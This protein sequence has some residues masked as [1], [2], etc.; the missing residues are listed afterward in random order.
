[1]VSKRDNVQGG[2]QSGIDPPSMLL[3]LR[4]CSLPTPFLQGLGGMSFCPGTRVAAGWRRNTEL[5]QRDCRRSAPRRLD[6][7]PAHRGVWPARQRRSRGEWVGCSPG[8]RPTRPVPGKRGMHSAPWLFRS[9]R[10]DVHR[11]GASRLR[12][13]PAVPR[14]Y[15]EPRHLAQRCGC[16]RG[17]DRC[18]KERRHP[19][20]RRAQ[21]SDWESILLDNRLR[22][23]G[24]RYQHGCL[25]DGIGLHVRDHRCWRTTVHRVDMQSNQGVATATTQRSR[26]TRLRVSGEV[27]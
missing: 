24:G 27:S 11:A 21:N 4:M 1:M 14:V 12:L 3:L 23:G 6:G 16:G 2:R 17:P 25:P 15:R 10:R 9:S 18:R 8:R 5:P 20:A 19:V 13:V 7:P 26:P 22:A